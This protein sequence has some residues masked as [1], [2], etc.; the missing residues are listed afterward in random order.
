[1]S[2]IA[3]VGAFID[4][5][6]SLLCLGGAALLAE[7]AY[8]ILNLSAMPMYVTFTLKQEQHLGLIIS[9]FLLT[10]A[11]SRPMF[12]ALG[13]RVGRKP[14]LIAGPAVTA[15]TSYLTIKLHGPFVIFGLVALRAI[16]G[17][18]SGALWP[19]AFATIGDL[20]EERNRSA[21]MSML[22]VTYMS[23]LALGFLLGGLVNE[24][25]GSYSASFYLVS[26]LL[27]GCVAVLW[28][29][30][31][32]KAAKTR[33]PALHI[34]APLDIPTLEEPTAFRPRV[35]L[36][37][38]K[39][40]PDMLLLACVVFLGIGML[41]PIV[42]L[43]A[44]QYY[45]MTETQFGLAVAPVAASM[46]LTAVPLGRLGDRFG[47]C[48]AV[49]WGLL[50]SALA[51]WVLALFRSKLLAAGAGIVLGLGFTVSFPAW[52][53]LVSAATSSNRRGEVLGAVG[54]AQGLAAIVGASLGAFIYS[55]DLLSFPRLGV[56]NYNVPFWFCAILLSAGT[57]MSF[58]WVCGRHGHK[59]PGGGISVRQRRLV[60]VAA[61]VAA[62]ALS[63]WIGYRYTRPI[64]PDRVAWAWVRHLARGRP[65]RALKYTL[66]S[67]AG[68][69]GRS[70]S[71]RKSR[72]YHGWK[73]DLD[74]RYTVL[75]PEL[76]TSERAVV[77][78]RFTL[79]ARRTHIEHIELCK[80]HSG[81]WKVCGVWSSR[82]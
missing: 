70:A 55:S 37:S 61:I 41:M 48:V 28:G 47:K 7:L 60:V 13:D 75:Y 38:F 62:L 19:S 80:V 53:A 8:A 25:F 73:E 4:R 27:I 24:A 65:E 46:G 71:L 63:G 40:V 43:Y 77:P 57:V 12:G 21:A 10:E 36:Q 16:D 54:M 52:L 32:G 58:T 50:A 59:E 1:M 72:Q 66:P 39:E 45:G 18:G 26:A 31:P 30:F 74:A 67:A 3:V 20:V 51:M 49:C 2:R 22:N 56:V 15:I 35:L 78:V 11:V 81:E 23:G 17:L 14:L 82:N 64:P 9:T 76:L 34:E 42:K 69:D 68:W 79:R 44:V 33:D 29:L 6:R 5:Y